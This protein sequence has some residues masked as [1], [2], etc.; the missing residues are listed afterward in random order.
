M[1]MTYQLVRGD[2][3][4]KVQG[5]P[6]GHGA[7]GGPGGG[8]SPHGAGGPPMGGDGGSEKAGSGGSFHPQAGGGAGALSPGHPPANPPTGKQ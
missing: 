4:W 6:T 7:E 1:G 2:G 5:T 3:G 8:A